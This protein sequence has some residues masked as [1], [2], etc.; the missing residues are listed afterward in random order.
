MTTIRADQILL[1]KPYYQ[2][3]YCTLYHGDCRKLVPQLP[4]GFTATDVPYNQRMRY[5]NCTDDLPLDE[6]YKMLRI[7]C[8][9]P[10]VLI[11]YPEPMF[12]IAMQVFGRRPEEVMT[13]VYPSNTPRQF[14][15]ACWWGIKP[16][17][18]RA[19]QPYRNGFTLP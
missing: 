8:P 7:T 15:L 3:D 1:P 5:D 6:Y 19:R 4:R 11:H 2:D 10:C 9:T 14:R 17:F 13:W 12:D 18:R 16:D